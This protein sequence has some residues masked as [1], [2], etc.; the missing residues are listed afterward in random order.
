[1]INNSALFALDN[2]APTGTTYTTGSVSTTAGHVF[3][4]TAAADG[5][6]FVRVTNTH[7]SQTITAQIRTGTSTTLSDYTVA[8][9]ILAAGTS[10]KFYLTYGDA[11]QI[12]GSGAATTCALWL[13]NATKGNSA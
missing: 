11:L 6:A 5:P 9:G 8:A 2:G 3:S 10:M 1:M 12:K 4:V 7:G 13:W